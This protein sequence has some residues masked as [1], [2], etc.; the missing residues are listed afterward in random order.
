MAYPVKA[1]G[2]IGEGK[3][4]ADCH[5]ARGEGNP[6]LPDGMKVD[7][8]GQHLGDRPGRRLHLRRRRRASRHA[9]RT[10]VP[11]ANLAWGDDGSTLYITANTR[12]VAGQD[13]DEG[14]DTVGVTVP[15]SAGCKPCMR[16]RS[17]AGCPWH[18]MHGSPAPA[19]HGLLLAFRS[20]YVRRVAE[21]RFGRLHHGL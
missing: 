13:E 3:V 17:A 14:E 10:G 18:R 20:V 15:V 2:T 5:G 9:S 12:G 6:G 8:E 16:C 11:T 7:T 1:D 19:P 4:F 21:E